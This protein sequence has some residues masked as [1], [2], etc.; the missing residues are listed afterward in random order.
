MMQYISKCLNSKKIRLCM[1]SVFS[2]LAL[3]IHDNSFNNG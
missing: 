2:A 1:K 3:I